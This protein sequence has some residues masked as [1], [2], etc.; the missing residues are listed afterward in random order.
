[1]HIQPGWQVVG[2]HA[3]TPLSPVPD[4]V[5]ITCLLGFDYVSPSLLNRSN[6]K[7]R[8]VIISHLLEGY[9]WHFVVPS[10]GTATPPRSRT[11]RLPFPHFAAHS[12]LPQNL[13]A[14]PSLWSLVKG[15]LLEA[16]TWT[17]GQERGNTI[18]RPS[19][20]YKFLPI[21]F[22]FPSPFLSFSN[23]F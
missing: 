7:K 10:S 3:V 1:M 19:N 23:P 2:G 21:F 22:S 13:P 11:L 16:Y 18:L 8:E 9:V 20:A 4:H 14:L 12:Q 5:W 17:N 6:F 15:A